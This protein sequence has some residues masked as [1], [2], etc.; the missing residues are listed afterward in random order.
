MKKTFIAFLL[1]LYLI[2]GIGFGSINHYC[3]NEMTAPGESRCCSAEAADN[4]SA[5]GCPAEK[6]Q[7]S[8][9]CDQSAARQQNT[10]LKAALLDNCCEIQQ[11][12]HQLDNSSLPKNNEVSQAAEAGIEF[13]KN[14]PQHSQPFKGCG[15]AAS[16][17]PA[18]HI[19][20]PLLI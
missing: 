7:E 6:P 5:A 1:F 3:Q 20:L 15:R 16:A 18:A 14:Y 10:N 9:C 11:K 17:D 12:Y 19:N 8:S 4:S 2:S 13:C